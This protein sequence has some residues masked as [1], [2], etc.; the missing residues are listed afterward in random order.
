MN[1]AT[2]QCVLVKGPEIK[3]G[4]A[5]GKIYLMDTLATLCD[6]AGITLPKSNEFLNPHAKTNPKLRNPAND[7]EQ[8]QKPAEMEELLNSEMERHNDPYPLW[9]Q[10]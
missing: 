6:L 5:R 9:H 10:K 8:A 3:P 4:R 1:P 7:P 2:K